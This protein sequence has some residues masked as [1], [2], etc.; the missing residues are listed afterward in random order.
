MHMVHDF[1]LLAGAT[2]STVAP[3]LDIIVQEEVG[4]A[5]ARAR[6]PQRVSIHPLLT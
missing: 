5:D 3:E 4:H 1:S 6:P 2:P